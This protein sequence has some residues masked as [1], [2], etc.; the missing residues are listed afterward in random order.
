VE[1]R[2]DYIDWI[3]SLEDKLKELKIELSDYD[4]F[5]IHDA[6]KATEK[7]LEENK[8]N[9]YHFVDEKIINDYMTMAITNNPSKKEYYE[10][11]SYYVKRRLLHR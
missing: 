1:K 9:K 3:F 2:S 10:T 11:I 5:H 8:N 4:E 7:I 6:I